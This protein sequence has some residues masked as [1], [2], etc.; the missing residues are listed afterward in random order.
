MTCSLITYLIVRGHLLS[1]PLS[2]VARQG[3]TVQFNCST[4]LTAVIKLTLTRSGTSDI[5]TIFEPTSDKNGAV[6]PSFAKTN[7]FTVIKEA[8][9]FQNLV[10][11]NISYTDAGSYKC[12]DDDGFG[13]SNGQ[14]AAADL[15]VI[16]E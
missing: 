13:L 1:G 8:G 5:R 14:W 6:L 3:D 9:G 10:I 2:S 4:N 12:I 7:R 11:R 16:G 15:V